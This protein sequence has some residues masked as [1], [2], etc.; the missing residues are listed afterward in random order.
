MPRFHRYRVEGATY[1][2]TVVVEGRRHIF[3]EPA[4]RKCLGDLLR[5]CHTRWPFT[6]DALVLLPDHL[7]ALW[8]LPADDADYSRRWGWVKK[9]FTK[10]WLSNGGTEVAVSAAR[11]NAGYRGV[12]QPRFWEHTIRDETDF[13]NHADYIH[14][15]PVKHGHVSRPIDWPWSSFERWVTAGVYPTDWGASEPTLPWGQLETTSGE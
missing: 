5:E 11:S 10:W 14:Y 2:F 9:E 12:L 8:T 7:H 1:F 4:A 3:A 15:N 13:E 6:T